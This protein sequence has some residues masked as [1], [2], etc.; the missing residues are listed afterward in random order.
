MRIEGMQINDLPSDT[1][2]ASAENARQQEPRRRNTLAVTL[3]KVSRIRSNQA[4]LLLDDP[5]IE[6]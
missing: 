6:R 1:M 3:E 5:P 4:G 2:R